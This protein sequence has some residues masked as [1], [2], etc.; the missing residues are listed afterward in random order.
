MTAKPLTH[1]SHFVTAFPLDCINFFSTDRPLFAR[2]FLCTLDLQIANSLPHKPSVAEIKAQYP[3]VTV[4]SDVDF[5]R[6][7][8]LLM[9]MRENMSDRCVLGNIGSVKMSVEL[10]QMVQA[11]EDVY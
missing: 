3:G 6:I 8:Y 9:E 2:K 7:P 5:S 4:L 1:L 10:K 11:E